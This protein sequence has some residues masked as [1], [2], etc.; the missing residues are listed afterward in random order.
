MR[1]VFSRSVAAAASHR[2]QHFVQQQ[3]KHQVAAFTSVA[4]V[5]PRPPEQQVK[6]QVENVRI[7]IQKAKNQDELKELKSK[8]QELTGKSYDEANEY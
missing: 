4:S 1:P 7:Q 5:H 8:Y 6:W 2:P 3:L